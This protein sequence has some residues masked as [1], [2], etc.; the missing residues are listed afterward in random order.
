MIR[1]GDDAKHYWDYG[2]SL[3]FVFNNDNDGGEFGAKTLHCQTL[4]AVRQLAN[5]A[6]SVYVFPLRND[7]FHSGT[8]PFRSGMNHSSPE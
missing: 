5:P 3:V 1:S 4:S 7:S 6:L 8:T 2:G